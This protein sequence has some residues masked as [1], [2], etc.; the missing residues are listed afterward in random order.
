MTQDYE[1]EMQKAE[2]ILNEA[3]FARDTEDFNNIKLYYDLY[4]TLGE[5][6]LTNEDKE[7]FRTRL[8]GIFG[9]Y[10]Q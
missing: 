5:L 6:K 2:S 10:L 9:Q 8:D 4:D 1:Y 7:L 3:T